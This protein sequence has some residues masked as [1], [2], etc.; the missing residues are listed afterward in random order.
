[1][2]LYNDITENKNNNRG[3]T[4][5]RLRQQLERVSGELEKDRNMGLAEELYI[6]AAHNNIAKLPDVSFFA[7]ISVFLL[8]LPVF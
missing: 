6:S 5:S 1:M 2:Q 7:I 8:I 4:V 3:A